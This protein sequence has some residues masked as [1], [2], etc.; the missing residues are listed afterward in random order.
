VR[1]LVGEEVRYFL[2]EDRT[3]RKKKK[4]KEK[5]KYQNA[6]PMGWYFSPFTFSS[7]LFYLL[8][9]YISLLFISTFYSVITTTAVT[10]S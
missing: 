8:F 6:R 1:W 7:L 2:G 9:F 5:T 3:S 10:N 4:E